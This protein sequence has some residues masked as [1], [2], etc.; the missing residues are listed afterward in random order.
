MQPVSPGAEVA[1]QLEAAGSVDV[2]AEELAANVTSNRHDQQRA[3]GWSKPPLRPS[4]VAAKAT[5]N[6]KAAEHAWQVCCQALE[7]FLACS[8]QDKPC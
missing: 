4:A 5:C 1:A 8:S 3:Q 6:E 2:T 7:Q